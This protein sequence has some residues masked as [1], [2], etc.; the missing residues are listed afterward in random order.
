MEVAAHPV[1]E[2][3]A[4]QMVPV[5]QVEDQHQPAAD[6]I[7]VVGSALQPLQP[8]LETAAAE[9]YVDWE[10]A[11]PALLRSGWRHPSFSEQNCDVSELVGLTIF[12]DRTGTGIVRDKIGRIVGSNGAWVVFTPN[13]KKH[14][15]AGAEVTLR[16]KGNSGKQWLIRTVSGVSDDQRQAREL[17]ALKREYIRLGGRVNQI[18]SVYGLDL[19]AWLTRKIVEIRS[20][21]SFWAIQS[22]ASTGNDLLAVAIVGS[23]CYGAVKAVDSVQALVQ[24]ELCERDPLK[25]S[26]PGDDDGIEMVETVRAVP[27]LGAPALKPPIDD[28]H[29]ECDPKAQPAPA[30][31]INAAPAI[32]SV[33]GTNEARDQWQA[34]NPDL[35][36]EYEDWLSH[37]TTAGAARLRSALH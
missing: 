7:I 6:Q 18:P 26:P 14:A 21:K 20:R 22:T 29:H 2:T 12:V 3:V 24:R 10:A 15:G 16:R 11:V 30:P 31:P 37:R 9:G 35:V 17:F 25:V 19:E 5:L 32:L 27:M 1:V 28:G 33:P 8:G 23:V 36:E 4:P 34:E 13:S